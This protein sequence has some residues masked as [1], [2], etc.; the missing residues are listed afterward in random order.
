MASAN[1]TCL[2]FMNNNSKMNTQIKISAKSRQSLK[3]FFGSLGKFISPRF[4]MVFDCCSQ[5]TDRL[6]FI[7]YGHNIHV[8][9]KQDNRNVDKMIFQ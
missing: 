1:R 5:D 8:K 9:S 6:P 3:R 2:V 7:V 4:T